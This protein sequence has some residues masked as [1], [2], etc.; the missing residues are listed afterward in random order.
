MGRQM[1][2]FPLDPRFS[3]SL[4]SAKALHCGDE[5]VSIISLLSVE[6]IFFVPSKMREKADKAR[7]KYITAD[8]DHGTLLNIY[9]AYKRENGSRQWCYDTFI[10]ARVMGTIVEVRKQLVDLCT[11]AGVPLESCRDDSTAYRK[12]LLSGLFVNVATL[13]PDGTYKV[14][15]TGQSAGI[16]PGSVLF[17]QKPACVLFNEVVQTSKRYMRDCCILDLDWLA[18]T[19]PKFFRA[20]KK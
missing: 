3:R 20:V 6:S 15:R 8:G 19:V 17:G 16:H 1:A 12:A 9:K 14:L 7:R 10:N 5:L 2:Q 11:R 4:L 13:Q 18:Q